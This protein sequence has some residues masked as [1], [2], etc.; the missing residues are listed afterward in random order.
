[1]AGN[2][3]TINFSSI[4]FPWAI[5]NMDI[6][7]IITEIPIS[8]F[9]YWTMKTSNNPFRQTWDDFRLFVRFILAKSLTLPDFFTLPNFLPSTTFHCTMLRV[10][11][12]VWHSSCHSFYYWFRCSSDYRHSF[13]SDD[14]VSEFV[15]ATSNRSPFNAIKRRSLYAQHSQLPNIRF[16]KLQVR[17]IL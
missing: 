3:M 11:V 10:C 1:M 16:R 9:F 13:V 7:P 12:W 8:N 15:F 4:S 5:S 17:A 14:M 2:N 6:V